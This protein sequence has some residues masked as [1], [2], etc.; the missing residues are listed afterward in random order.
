M[1]ATKFHKDTT[2]NIEGK[3]QTFLLVEEQ[4]EKRCTTKFQATLARR[5]DGSMTPRVTA[6]A[7]AAAGLAAAAALALAPISAAAAGV[8]ASVHCLPMDLDSFN[9][10]DYIRWSNMSDRV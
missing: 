10:T 8:I 5:A 1:S 4:Q 2:V 7:A 9:L 6:T 3:F